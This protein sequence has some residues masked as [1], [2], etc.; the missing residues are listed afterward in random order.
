MTI[1]WR[2]SS[3]S[4]SAN[5]EMCIELA[6][7]GDGIWV[8]DSKAPATGH[9]TMPVSTFADLLRRIKT[10]HPTVTVSS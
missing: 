9:L 8:R 4:G 5:D 1:H 3:Y 2:K 7:P 10:T 6:A